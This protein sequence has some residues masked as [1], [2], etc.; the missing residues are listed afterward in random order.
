VSR[1][2]RLREEYYIKIWNAAY[3][4]SEKASHTNPLIPSI[5]HRMT[6]ALWP[7]HILTQFLTNHDCFRSYL[8]KRKR[9]PHHYV[10]A[11]KRLNKRPGISCQTAAYSPKTC[12][13][14]KTPP[15]PN[16]AIPQKHGRSIQTNKKHLPHATGTIEK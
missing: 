15:T 2:K 7:N 11:P 13:V 1:G 9:G 6:L 14:S 12:G 8:Y 3:I 16:N 4:N 10:V 5:L